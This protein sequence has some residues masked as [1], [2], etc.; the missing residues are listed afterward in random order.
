MAGELF[1]R[2]A[3]GFVLAIPCAPLVWKAVGRFRAEREKR[4]LRNEFRDY[5]YAV[6]SA[7][8]AGKPLPAALLDADRSVAILYPEGRSIRLFSGRIV[9]ELAETETPATAVVE[10]AARESGVAEIRTFSGI[11][12]V[13]TET[14]AD[15]ATAIGKTETLLTGRIETERRIE[16]GLAEKKLELWILTAMPLLILAFL[17]LSSADYMAVLY[18]SA[19]GRAVMTV[20]LAAMTGAVLWARNMMKT[21][22]DER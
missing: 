3:Y 18:E 20:A 14:G 17:Q 7:A 2:T 16:S 9:R 4:A 15:L 11:C 5:L 8:A 6:S 19:N 10:L 21:T 13:C 1:Y 12:S 22:L